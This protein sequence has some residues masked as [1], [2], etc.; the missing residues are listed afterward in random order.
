[1]HF[2]TI[3]QIFNQMNSFSKEIKEKQETFQER[4]AELEK[5]INDLELEKFFKG[6]EEI[7]LKYRLREEELR[8]NCLE[9]T[10]KRVFLNKKPGQLVK[11]HW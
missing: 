5:K 3:K 9:T 4:H 8:K 7:Q 1:M 6:S 11:Y 10:L 2:K